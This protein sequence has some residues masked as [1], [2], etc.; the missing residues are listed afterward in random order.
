M[1][2]CHVFRLEMEMTVN[3]EINGCES[4]VE[5][6]SGSLRWGVCVALL[7]CCLMSLSPPTRLLPTMR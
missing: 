6:K 4:V 3:P 1:T 2:G 5:F 7:L